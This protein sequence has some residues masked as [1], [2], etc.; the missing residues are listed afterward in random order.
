MILRI[1]YCTTGLCL[2]IVVG[3][4]IAEPVSILRAQTEPEKTQQQK[5][6]ENSET[7]ATVRKERPPEKSTGTKKS[8]QQILRDAVQRELNLHTA[9]GKIHT[10]VI[11][12]AAASRQ[13]QKNK[14]PL[15]ALR[16][17]PH[18]KIRK[19]Q[20]KKGSATQRPSRNSSRVVKIGP[21]NTKPNTKKILQA[22]AKGELAEKYSKQTIV[23]AVQ[24][25]KP[26]ES[27]DQ[28]TKAT[29]SSNAVPAG[30]LK[31]G[32]KEPGKRKSP[33]LLKRAINGLN[34]R[35]EPSSKRK[36]RSGSSA[37][38]RFIPTNPKPF[39][40]E[41]SPIRQ[42]GETS[43]QQTLVQSQQNSAIS[44]ELEKLYRKDGREMPAFR[45]GTG[46]QIPQGNAQFQGIAPNHSP[47]N[48]QPEQNQPK[49]PFWKRLFSIG[50]KPQQQRPQQQPPRIPPSSYGS[51]NK[52]GDPRGQ[53]S[54]NIP[55]GR[56]NST[57]ISRNPRPFPG[58][59][60]DR[61]QTSG[62]QFQPL[63]PE[64]RRINGDAPQ[65]NP[66]SDAFDPFAVP[67]EITTPQNS[68]DGSVDRQGLRKSDPLSDEFNPF[69]V[70]EETIEDQSGFTTPSQDST[71]D[72]SSDDFN[73]FDEPEQ[74][75]DNRSTPSAAQKRLSEETV[76]DYD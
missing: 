58:G 7:P 60:L 40:K 27:V 71:S 29:N 19:P 52:P 12:P 17:K 23:N 38:R 55:F 75:A 48:R 76:L 74:K 62:D 15:V 2:C 68:Y 24:S 4:L 11:R 32:K 36:D 28:P 45:L 6:S 5:Q 31:F 39:S 54:R 66:F 56:Q 67:Q 35:S 46:N 69:D 41:P 34:R 16:R 18:Q 3:W 59:A 72:P 64:N 37:P 30:Y 14:P 65:F 42:T 10:P 9:S 57:H 70:P 63:N 44:Q 25:G 43:P 51:R 50:R 8:T 1:A 21:R 61:G 26:K 47:G 33:S 73:P 22:G 20:S 13:S 53:N 49:R